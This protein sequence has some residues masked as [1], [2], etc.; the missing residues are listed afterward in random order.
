MDTSKEGAH[1]SIPLE[2]VHQS[3]MIKIRTATP[4]DLN[5]I[6]LIEQYSFPSPYS[7][8]LTRYLMETASDLFLVAISDETSISKEW[9]SDIVGFSIA[10]MYEIEELDNRKIDWLFKFASMNGM[11]PGVKIGH[12]IDIAVHPQFRRQG[13]GSML[14]KELMRR[15]IKKGCTQI[16]LEVRVSNIAAQ[17]MYEK[18]GF[19]SVEIVPGFYENKENAMVLVFTVEEPL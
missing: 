19:Q 4:T 2:E 10:Q 13:I 3:E 5:S 14:L 1:I 17:K 8:D 6:Q 7:T 12:V 15:L 9:E 16:R 11:E 18:F